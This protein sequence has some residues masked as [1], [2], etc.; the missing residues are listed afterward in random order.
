MTLETTHRGYTIQYSENQ[1]KWWSHD[2][3]DGMEAET[4]S[5][6]KDKIDRMIAKSKKATAV[7]FLILDN[8]QSGRKTTLT[9]AK[10]TGYIG[11]KV[12]NKTGYSSEKVVK[13]HSVEA[14]YVSS[15]WGRPDEK[16]ARR[17][18]GLDNCC[19][20][21]PEVH[22]ALADANRLGQ[23]AR[24]ADEDYR[25]AVGAIPRMTLEDIDHLVKLSGVDP[26]GGLG[27]KP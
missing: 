20:D 18:T 13:G 14:V 27:V 26:T 25:K 6:M 7:H 5:K 21:T 10:M 16:A 23:L 11:P 8:D 19:P 22:A 24:Q 4:L 1:D 17:S 9:E 2:A 3:G 15:R 12:V